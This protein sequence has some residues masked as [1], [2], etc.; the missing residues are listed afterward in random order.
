MKIMYYGAMLIA[1]FAL[2][3]A[4]YIAALKMIQMIDA[5]KV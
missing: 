3:Y 1:S 5:L 2:L 4:I